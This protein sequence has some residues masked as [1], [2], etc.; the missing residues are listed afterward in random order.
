ML[1]II[2][3]VI[4]VVVIIAVVIIVMKKK[5]ASESSAAAHSAV[6]FENPMVS[7]SFAPALRRVPSPAHGSLGP[8]SVACVGACGEVG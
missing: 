3:V 2:I 7:V 8:S 1:L 4:A 5:N 6:S